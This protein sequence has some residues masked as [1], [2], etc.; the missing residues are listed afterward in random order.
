MKRGADADKKLY[1]ELFRKIK[2]AGINAGFQN[3]SVRLAD[4]AR[5][6]LRPVFPNLTIFLAVAFLASMFFSVIAAIISDSLDKTIRD[7]EQVSRVLKTEVIGTLPAMK[8]WRNRLNPVSSVS[9]DLARI[10]G[11]AADHSLS[12][13]EEAIRT[14]RNSILLA[15]FDRRL[16]SVLI[17]SASPAEGKTTVAAHLAAAHAEQHHKTLLIDCDLRRPSRARL[18][19]WKAVPVF[20]RC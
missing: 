12:G 6:A 14:L 11:S 19:R 17:T 16:R 13:Y 10:D 2:E 4:A 7:P 18:F 9:M 3:S 8:S 15:D 20:P 5:P 1:D